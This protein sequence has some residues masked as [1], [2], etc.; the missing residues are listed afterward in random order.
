MFAA[1]HEVTIGSG[2]LIPDKT[3]PAGAV[4]AKAGLNGARPRKEHLFQMIDTKIARWLG[5]DHTVSFPWL[6]P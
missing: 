3:C 2:A 1:G 5:K 6:Y 4:K